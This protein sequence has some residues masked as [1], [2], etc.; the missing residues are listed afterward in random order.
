MRQLHNHSLRGHIKPLAN[1][2][3]TAVLF[4]DSSLKTG[5]GLLTEPVMTDVIYPDLFPEET[6][7]MNWS[8]DLRSVTPC[9][10]VEAREEVNMV[11]EDMT[12]WRYS[13]TTVNLQDHFSMRPLYIYL[14]KGS[15]HKV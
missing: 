13:C 15:L 9:G 7:L 1:G 6:I 12:A 10:T 4:K 14:L 11:K 2:V 5:A 8:V 3:A